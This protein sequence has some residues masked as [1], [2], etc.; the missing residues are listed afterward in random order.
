M[1]NKVDLVSWTELTRQCSEELCYAKECCVLKC[2]INVTDWTCNTELRK[3]HKY[4]II[5]CGF[6][7]SEN[8]EKVYTQILKIGTNKTFMKIGYLVSFHFWILF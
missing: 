1:Y 5:S 7:L 8:L 6:A 2:K 3:Q 4:V